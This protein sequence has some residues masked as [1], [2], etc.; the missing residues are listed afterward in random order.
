MGIVSDTL[1]KILMIGNSG[2]G[3]S[4]LRL[5]VNSGRKRRKKGNR[6]QEG[7]EALR[8]QFEEVVKYT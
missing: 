4:S 6:K 7:V 1:L 8:L 3:K 2:M 5:Q